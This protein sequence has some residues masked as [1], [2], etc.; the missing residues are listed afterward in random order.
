MR[1]FKP[2]VAKM[3]A[4]RDVDGLC[5][6]LQDTSETVRND[7]AEALGKIGDVRAVEPLIIALKSYCKSW[8]ECWRIRQSAAD[9]LVKLGSAAVEPLISALKDSD[10]D[11]RQRAA[12]ALEKIA[13]A[14]AVE[15]FIIALKD[16][17]TDVRRCAASALE[18][19]GD[20]RAVESLIGALK[21]S[22][23]DCYTLA[24]SG[25]VK[26]GGIA[27]EQLI[28]A[29]KDSDAKVR[30]RAAFVLDRIGD[31]RAVEPLIGA[32]KDSASGVRSSAASALGNIGDS[33][34]I[35]PL[36]IAL[37]ENDFL[38][39]VAAIEALGKVGDTQAVHPLCAFL[40]NDRLF[41]TADSALK[42]IFNR[43]YNAWTIDDL[44][45]LARLE[46]TYFTESTNNCGYR[47]GGGIQFDRSQLKQLAR[48]ELIRRG[49]E[50]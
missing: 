19:I 38:F 7:A 12:S 40:N 49:L 8:L 44:H 13:D 14:R 9:A 21:D 26:L 24:I 6:A 29:L 39:Q 3:Q 16:I 41:I 27:V 11:V 32:L 17:D 33:R 43:S 10:V 35:E 20:A 45:W 25:L 15:P 47:V 5:K 4:N 2:N 28:I 22:D 1:F 36:I 42:A 30:Y 46:N 37:N 48:Q 31:A 23:S 18:K 50:A 34:A